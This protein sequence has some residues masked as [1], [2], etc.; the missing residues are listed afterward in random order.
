MVPLRAADARELTLVVA[1]PLVVIIIILAL[2]VRVE[3]CARESLAC[4]GV[5]VYASESSRASNE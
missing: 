2:R 5:G 1:T 4:V 3:A